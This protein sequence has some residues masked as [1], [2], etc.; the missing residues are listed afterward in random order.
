MLHKDFI[1]AMSAHQL[2]N[3]DY[4]DRHSH[5]CRLLLDSKLYKFNYKYFDLSLF[6]MTF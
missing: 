3:R 4:M 5:Y 6:F 1:E 2:I